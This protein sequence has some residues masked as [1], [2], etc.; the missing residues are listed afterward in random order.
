MGG[1]QVSWGNLFMD[2]A[3]C[4]ENYALSVHNP[5]QLDYS[6]C[7]PE[8]VRYW[9]NEKDG[10]PATIVR[11]FI[12]ESVGSLYKTINFILAPYAHTFTH[13]Q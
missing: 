13:K 10:G 1:V 8:Y 4:Y 11:K 5:I 12:Y 9:L 3:V 6:V 7:N 2:V